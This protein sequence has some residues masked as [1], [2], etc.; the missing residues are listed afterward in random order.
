M[1]KALII[2][3]CLFAVI[4]SSCASSAQNESY[5]NYQY[6]NMSSHKDDIK[7]EEIT[8]YIPYDASYMIDEETG[9]NYI[10]IRVSNGGLCII[11]RYNPDGSLYVED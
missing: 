6:E 7:F 9:V 2:F 10:V 8:D 4:F 5:E 1:K 3:S 11:P